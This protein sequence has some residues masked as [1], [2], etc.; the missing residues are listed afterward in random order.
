MPKVMRVVG[1]V[2]GK[3]TIRDIGKDVYYNDVVDIQEADV[4]RSNDIIHAFKERWIDVIFGKELLDNHPRYSTPM[5]M[6]LG[7]RDGVNFNGDPTPEKLPAQPQF[8]VAGLISGLHASIREIIKSEMANNQSTTIINQTTA[9]DPAAPTA[10]DHEQLA[11]LIAGQ[12]AGKLQVP[13]GNSDKAPAI[14]KESQNVF[15]NLD[16]NTDLKSNMGDSGLGNVVESSDGKAND[17][18]K[19]LSQLKKKD[20][21]NE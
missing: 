13:A 21:S 20:K 7:S 6:N 12:L 9:S 8:D 16:D 2:V 15:I 17:A 4:L 5:N 11:T 14:D 10:V 3:V 18:I 1:K 19:R